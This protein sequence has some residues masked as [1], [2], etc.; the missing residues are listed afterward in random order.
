MTKL[1]VLIYDSL[2]LHYLVPNGI[3]ADALRRCK[4]FC[5]YGLV[6]SGARV[7][8]FLKNGEVFTDICIYPD[9]TIE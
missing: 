6:A 4:P 1:C 7:Q 8:M 2:N 5:S 3:A 9:L